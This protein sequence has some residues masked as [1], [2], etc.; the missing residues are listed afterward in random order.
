[1]ARFTRERSGSL[2]ARVV[3]DVNALEAMIQAG[4]SR[5]LGR[6]FGIVVVLVILFA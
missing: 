2:V 6:L 5:I 4:A 3:S 1:M